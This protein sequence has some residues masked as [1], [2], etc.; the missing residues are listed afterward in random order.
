MHYMSMQQF[1]EKSSEDIKKK[2]DEL[3]ERGKGKKN[4]L[5][6]QEIVD[7]FQDTKVDDD[8]MEV[9]IGILEKSNIDVLRVEPRIRERARR[10]RL[11]LCGTLEGTRGDLLRRRPA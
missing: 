5:D 2:I 9:F 11:Q 7:T 3:I 10:R 8:Q 4:V 1:D 6:Y